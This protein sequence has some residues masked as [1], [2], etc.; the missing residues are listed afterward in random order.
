MPHNL[1]APETLKT[2]LEKHPEW[3]DLPLVVYCPDGHYDWV[4]AAGSAYPSRDE[5]EG[6]DVLVF[7]A[8]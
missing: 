4:G 2:L 1:E 3:G 5:N 7:S 8:N 6:I